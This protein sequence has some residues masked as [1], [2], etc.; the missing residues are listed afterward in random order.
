MK[1]IFVIN[2]GSTSTKIAYF[3]EDKCLI[4]ENLQH[5]AEEIKQ[6]ETIW[7]QF[8]LRKAAIDAFLEEHNIKVSELDAFVSRDRKSVV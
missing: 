6:Y 8:D 2:L 5:P 4:K 1:K 7:E 3:E